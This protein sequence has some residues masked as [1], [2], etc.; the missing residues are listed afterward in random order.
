MSSFREVKNA[1]NSL[2]KTGPL[3]G[4]HSTLFDALSAEPALA[5][6]IGKLGALLGGDVRTLAHDLAVDFG[7]LF[8]GVSGP[9]TVSPYESA[10]VSARGILFQEPVGEMNTVIAGLG[11]SVEDTFTEPSDHL[12]VELAVMSEMARRQ[13][14][15]GASGEFAAAAELAAAQRRL[16]DDHL[17]VWLPEFR[18]GCAAQAPD[19]LYTVAAKSLLGYARQDR[20]WLEES[21][22]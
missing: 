19:S 1:P 2:N 17:L 8:Y 10:Y 21:T 12:A 18:D 11:L 4:G 7:K 14:A 20:D 16:L 6:T 9:K 15:A 5:P 13:D 3:P 22:G